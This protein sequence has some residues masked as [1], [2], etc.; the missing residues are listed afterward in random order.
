MLFEILNSSREIQGIKNGPQPTETVLLQKHWMWIPQM[1]QKSV[2]PKL[3]TDMMKRCFRL[4]VKAGCAYI[5]S[6][7]VQVRLIQIVPELKQP[8]QNRRRTLC[9]SVVDVFLQGLIS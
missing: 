7:P 5:S 3:G 4:T 9:P 2:F 6:D 1:K 8:R